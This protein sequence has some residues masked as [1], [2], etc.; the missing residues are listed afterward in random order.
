MSEAGSTSRITSSCLSSHYLRSKMTMFSSNEG[1][2]AG[3][4][5]VFYWGCL[6]FIRQWC[7]STAGLLTMGQVGLHVVVR[8]D[9]RPEARIN[10]LEWI[11]W[12]DS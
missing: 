9:K 7:A 2:W 12:R 8:I 3:C 1:D 11:N 5:E 4:G 6:H 10:D